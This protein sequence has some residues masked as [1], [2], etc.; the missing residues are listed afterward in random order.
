MFQTGEE[1]V[2]ALGKFAGV[3]AFEHDDTGE[4]ESTSLLTFTLRIQLTYAQITR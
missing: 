1:G 4:Q 3:A 2:D